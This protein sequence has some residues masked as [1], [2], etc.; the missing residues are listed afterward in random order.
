MKHIITVFRLYTLAPDEDQWEEPNN[1][2]NVPNHDGI[3]II[4]FEEDDIVCS[5]GCCMKKKL[6]SFAIFSAS[7]AAPYNPL[8]DSPTQY[9]PL[10]P[11]QCIG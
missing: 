6:I 4:M 10:F 9:K 5:Q 11:F 8:L 1:K 3:L 2:D 7:A